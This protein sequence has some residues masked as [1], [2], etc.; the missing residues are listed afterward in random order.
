V[1]ESSKTILC[2]KWCIITDE[3]VDFNRS[4]IV[5]IDREN[6]TALV[7]EIADPLTHNL[8]EAEKK[9]IRKYENLAQ[10]IKNIFEFN[11]VTV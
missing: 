7:I 10:E 8:P 5:L 9:I 2:C 4:D 1:L 11:N 6:K 3:K